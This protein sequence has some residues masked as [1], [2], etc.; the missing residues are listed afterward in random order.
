VSWLMTRQARTL[1]TEPTASRM[2]IEETLVAA[3]HLIEMEPVAP[4]GDQAVLMLPSR[5]SP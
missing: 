1:P 5:T 3:S 2:L 4:A